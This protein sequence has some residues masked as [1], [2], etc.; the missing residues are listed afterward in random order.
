MD[1]II[2]ALWIAVVV[3]GAAL[4]YSYVV[5]KLLKTRLDLL[6]FENKKLK[7]IIKTKDRKGKGGI[8]KSFICQT[9][10]VLAYSA[11]IN[12]SYIS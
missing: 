11:Y 4:C 8:L 5:N 6:D 7:E 10:P 9:T 1:L 2:W 3:L 12:P